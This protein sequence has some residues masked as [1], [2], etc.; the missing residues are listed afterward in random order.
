MSTGRRR[1]AW[2]RSENAK[3]VCAPARVCNLAETPAIYPSTYFAY[4]L[5][6]LSVAP[7]QL[8]IKPSQSKK[9]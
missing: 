6:Q 9:H 7:D 8:A 2:L 3:C 4:V 1:G 5:H